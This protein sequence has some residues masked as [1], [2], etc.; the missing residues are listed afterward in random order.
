MN[1]WSVQKYTK[2]YPFSQNKMLY[3]FINKQFI[4][5]LYSEFFAPVNLRLIFFN[6]RTRSIFFPCKDIIPD[7]VKCNIAYINV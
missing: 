1:W 5:K 2:R 7:A 6:D 3:G 4:Y